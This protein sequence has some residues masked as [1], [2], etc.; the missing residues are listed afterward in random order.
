MKRPKHKDYKTT[1]EYTVA[2]EKYVDWLEETI[3]K[4]VWSIVD[5]K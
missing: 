4:F 3:N 5:M 1:W 2:L